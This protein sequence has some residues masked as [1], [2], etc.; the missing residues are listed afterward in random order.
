MDANYDR[1]QNRL[2][3]IEGAHGPGAAAG[4]TV[5]SDGLVVPRK[6]PGLKLGVPWRSLMLAAT[7]CFLLKGFMIWHQGEAGYAACLTDLEAQGGGHATAAWLL[8]MD[9]V[10]VAIAGLMT[11]VIGRPPS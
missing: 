10:S 3:R 5:R 4:L 8:S 1:F 9:P 11:D 6:R 2:R 7:C